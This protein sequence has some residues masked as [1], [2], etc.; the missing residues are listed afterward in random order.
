ML[1]WGLA[2]V[3]HATLLATSAFETGQARY[4]V[5]LHVLDLTLLLW[6]ATRLWR[7][8]RNRLA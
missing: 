7:R 4:T 3:V 6:L 8:R 2:L 1:A 5:A